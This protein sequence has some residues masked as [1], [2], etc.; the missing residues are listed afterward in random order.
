MRKV[1]NEDTH[2]EARLLQK[3]DWQ[4]IFDRIYKEEKSKEQRITIE[5]DS[6][7]LGVQKEVNNVPFQGI[8]YDPKD[9]LVAVDA[10]NMDHLINHPQRIAL[11]TSGQD[12][13]C[14]EVVDADS[15][16]HLVYFQPPLRLPPI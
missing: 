16:R 15:Q 6:E 3:Q 4:K 9:D 11:A 1:A 5:V 7:G 10:D 12:L 13:V 14:I 2:M 8:S